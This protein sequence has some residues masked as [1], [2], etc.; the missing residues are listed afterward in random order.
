MYTN[1]EEKLLGIY[2]IYFGEN[3]EF[4]DNIA[5]MLDD[6]IKTLI[7]NELLYFYKLFYSK[8]SIMNG[9]YDIIEPQNLK[10]LNNTIMFAEEEQGVCGYLIDISS[11]DVYYFDDDTK[12]KESSLEDFLIYLLAIQG[13]NF[14]CSQGLISKS[15]DITSFFKTFK[16]GN[17]NIYISQKYNTLGFDYDDEYIMLISNDELENFADDSNIL[18]DYL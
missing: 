5:S 15:E 9:S 3:I 18:I 10:V 13:T 12:E 8:T 1:F 4:T 7:P 16:A 2:Q 14:L 17:V 6:E 11:K